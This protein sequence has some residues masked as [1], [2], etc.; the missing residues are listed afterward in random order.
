MF[1]K[2]EIN[3]DTYHVALLAIVLLVAVTIYDIVGSILNACCDIIEVSHV[4]WVRKHLIPNYA[5]DRFH[6]D[7][8]I[9][10]YFHCS[11]IDKV[12]LVLLSKV[13]A[14]LDKPISITEFHCMKEVR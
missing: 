5:C 11:L 12:E 8:S 9:I 1:K 10:Q 13:C 4:V 7:R 6:A 3:K 2:A 14:F